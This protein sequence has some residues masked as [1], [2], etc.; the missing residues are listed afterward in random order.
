M[1]DEATTA[2]QEIDAMSRDEKRKLE[3]MG[4]EISGNKLVL[5]ERL[6]VALTNENDEERKDDK[7]GEKSENDEEEILGSMH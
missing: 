4:L 3:E 1:A 7:E 2:R 5:K 6:R